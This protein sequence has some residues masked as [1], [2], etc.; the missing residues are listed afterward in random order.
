MARRLS[1]LTVSHKRTETTKVHRS[2]DVEG[3]EAIA[4]VLSETFISQVGC[5]LETSA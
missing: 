5:A 1:C 3:E 2:S 4:L